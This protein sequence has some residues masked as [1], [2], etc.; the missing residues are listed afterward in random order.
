MCEFDIRMLEIQ[1]I[2]ETLNLSTIFKNTKSII[3]KFTIMYRVISMAPLLK[4]IIQ[5]CFPRKFH[6]NREI[7]HPGWES[8]I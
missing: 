8:T 4:F 2:E 6:F 3:N 7:P 1:I 5:L